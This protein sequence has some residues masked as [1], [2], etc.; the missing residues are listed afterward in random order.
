MRLFIGLQWLRG[1][2]IAVAT[3]G[4]YRTGQPQGRGTTLLYLHHQATGFTSS[5]N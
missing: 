5:G 1:E 4:T 3:R 2:L